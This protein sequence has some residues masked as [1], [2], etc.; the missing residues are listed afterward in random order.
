MSIV[1]M[2]ALTAIGP[3]RFECCETIFEDREVVAACRR[4]LV[5]VR[6]TGC[7]MSWRTLTAAAAARWNDS[8]MTEGCM[9]FPSNLSAAPNK[10]PA[11]TTTDVVPS[12]AST[13]WA[14]ERSTS[15]FAEGCITAMLF[16]I[17][18]PSFVIIVSPFDVCIILSSRDVLA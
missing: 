11:I 7:D 13:S 9:P 8:A 12:P 17:V 16:N 18:D 1:L 6:E 4:V 3:R 15:I 5:S 14:A 10:L 2:T